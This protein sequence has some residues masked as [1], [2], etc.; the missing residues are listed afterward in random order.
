MNKRNFWKTVG[1]VGVLLASAAVGA[2][3]GWLPALFDGADGSG[4]EPPKLAGAPK[5]AAAAA[6]EE[7]QRVWVVLQA[8]DREA[9]TRIARTGVSIEQVSAGTVAG[10]ADPVILR[11]LRQ[12]GVPILRQSPLQAFG[13]EGFAPDDQAYHDY[14]EVETELSAIASANPG[15]ASMFSIGSSVQGRRLLGVRFNASASGL[16]P[17]SKP[18]AV[19]LGAHHARE[20]LSTEVPLLLAKWLAENKTRPDVARL[21][22][23]RDL[24]FLPLINPDGSEY[25]IGNESAGPPC[26]SGRRAGKAR[27]GKSSYRWQRKN[28]RC[29]P[30]GSR[31]VD[32]NRNYGYHWNEGGSSDY[33]GSDVYHGPSPFSEPEARAVKAFL[34]SRGNVRV[35]V[36]Y[37]TY[38]ELILYPWGYS[39]DP[40]PDAP[41]LN[42]YR[43]MASKMAEMTGYTPQQS[44]DLYAASGDMTDWSWG[45]RKIFSFTFELTPKSM[46]EGGFYPGAGAISSTF[47]KNIGPALYLADLADD[48]Y[49]AGT[50]SVARAPGARR[51]PIPGGRVRPGLENVE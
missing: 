14:S 7:E 19:F 1:R 47:Q 50:G 16:E 43:A 34:E 31:G 10:V 20:H 28:M 22:D 35:L 9:R 30:D 11:R 18:G 42:A 8:A 45:E 37:H 17:S 6:A 48:P 41:A 40:I 26:G 39:Y 13:P 15:L 51:R 2:S 3:A 27:G 24:Y 23:G 49:R 46:W 38:S 4:E 29:N 25:D 21:L 12:L 36:S 44:S 33:P 5:P 32:L